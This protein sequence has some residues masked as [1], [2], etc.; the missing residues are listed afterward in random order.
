MTASSVPKHDRPRSTVPMSRAPERALFAVAA[1]SVAIAVAL[2]ADQSSSPGTR[3]AAGPNLPAPRT[4]SPSSSKAVHIL[5]TSI[6]GIGSVLVG[7]NAA[8]LYTYAPDRDNRVTCI[9]ACAAIF[10]PVML[11]AGGRPVAYR[12]V[13]QSLLG[14]AP[15]PSGGRVVTYARWPL[16][17]YTFEDSPN[18]A[19]GQGLNVNGGFLP[20]VSATAAGLWHVINPSG[21][22]IVNE[23]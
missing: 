17:T 9:R 13:K 7:S 21:N 2:I 23:R 16:Y 1:M 3:P 18:E 15:D 10:A 20:A 4:A 14:T 8:T 11:P 12:P 19:P 6:A 22:V 5:S